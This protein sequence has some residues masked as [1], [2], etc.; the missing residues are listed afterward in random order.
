[1]IEEILDLKIYL[2]GRFEGIIPNIDEYVE[3]INEANEIFQIDLSRSNSHWRN[4]IH[5]SLIS[6]YL[7]L[8]SYDL[9]YWNLY[10]NKKDEISNIFY[11]TQA[12]ED[13]I[14]ELFVIH[15]INRVFDFEGN[16]FEITA[17]KANNDSNPTY[18]TDDSNTP[19]YLSTD[20]NKKILEN[21]R[22]AMKIRGM[23]KKEIWGDND[24]IVTLRQEGI[25]QQ[26][27]IISCKLSLRER[28]YQSVFWSMHS[29]LE[30][31]GKHVF[32][33]TDKGN[34]G[35]S[36]IGIRSSD[37]SARKSRDVLE[38][39][40]DR[41]YVL[42]NSIEVNRSQVIKDFQWLRNDLILWANEISGNYEI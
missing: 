12:G 30:G 27:C 39:T 2:S 41:V 14:L 33:T 24:I 34:S 20:E 31:I 16:I 37:N 38:S 13:K 15:S 9:E 42:R 6:L 32:V 21:L 22:V 35:S 36:E 8:H 5:A 23:P 17:L 18:L 40:M 26:F 7:E 19:N 4:Y 28:V 1:M 10:I 3:E 29:R 25:I 11:F